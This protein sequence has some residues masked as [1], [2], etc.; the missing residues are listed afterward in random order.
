MDLKAACVCTQGD[1]CQPGA[2]EEILGRHDTTQPIVTR[3]H[4]RLCQALD[5]RHEHVLDK[6]SEGGVLLVRGPVVYNL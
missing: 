2:C 6:D 5:V 4:L 1:N 3:Y